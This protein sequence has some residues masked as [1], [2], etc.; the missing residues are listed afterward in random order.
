MKTVKLTSK[1]LKDAVNLLKGTDAIRGNTSY[2]SSVYINPSDYKTLEKNVKAAFKKECPHISI[3]GLQNAVGVHLLCYGPV[4]SRG[5][6][7]GYALVDDKALEE[8]ALSEADRVAVNG[9]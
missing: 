3:R 4:E 6:A 5:V 7:K 9:R 2:P 8:E 1:L